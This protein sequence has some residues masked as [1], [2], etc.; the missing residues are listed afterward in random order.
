MVLIGIG[1]G[2]ICGGM[3]YHGGRRDGMRH[4]ASELDLSDVTRQLQGACHH[5]AHDDVARHPL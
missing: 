3:Q 4:G 1:A 2:A 5:V